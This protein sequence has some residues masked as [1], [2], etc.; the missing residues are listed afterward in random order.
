MPA[1]PA[2]GAG[3]RALPT[4]SLALDHQSALPVSWR[5]TWFI[6]A[7]FACHGLALALVWWQPAWAVAAVLANHGLIVAATLWPRSQWFGPNVVRLPEASRRRGE[8]SI[9][10]DDGPD[11]AVT[12]RVLDLLARAGVRASFFCIADQV[13][14]HPALAREIVA[15]GH[16][17]QNH[18]A[19]HSHSFSLL[20]RRGYAGELARAQGLIESVTGQQPRCFR[21]P[22]GFR[23]PFLAPVLAKLGL[24]LVSWTRRGFDTRRAEPDRV[25]ES[26]TRDLSAGDILLLHDGHAARSAAGEPVILQVL[27]RLIERCQ[28]AGLRPVRLSDALPEARA[29]G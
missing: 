18:T 6:Q 12:P 17:I 16:D 1:A 27:P 13:A 21:A 26:L 25:L 4:M 22:A 29:H 11:P 5:P 8:V 15:R 24:T 10:I 7:T 28:A 23:N 9:T 2:R 19:S 3:R 20:G 14:A